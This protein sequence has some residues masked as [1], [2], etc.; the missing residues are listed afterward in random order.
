MLCR[1]SLPVR[2][3]NAIYFFFSSEKG[4]VTNLSKIMQLASSKQSLDP[5]LL[6]FLSALFPK[7][8]STP[9]HICAMYAI[10][11]HAYVLHIDSYLTSLH[12]AFESDVQKGRK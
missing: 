10:N 1:V 11:L 9:P 6:P 3:Y 4:Y 8:P 7:F 5:G 12:T 2:A